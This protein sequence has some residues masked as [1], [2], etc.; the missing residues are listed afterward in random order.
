M[1]VVHP[2]PTNV[3]TQIESHSNTS[4][5]LS[6]QSLATVLHTL[7]GNALSACIRFGSLSATHVETIEGAV[8]SCGFSDTPTLGSNGD[9]S[10]YWCPGEHVDTAGHVVELVECDLVVVCIEK[11]ELSV[12]HGAGL[13]VFDTVWHTA[14]SDDL[15][16]GMAR[17]SVSS[18]NTVFDD[19]FNISALPDHVVVMFTHTVQATVCN[20]N[21]MN[22]TFDSTN[23]DNFFNT[24]ILENSAIF[25]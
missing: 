16:T 19:W 4:P 14:G 24:G 23:P 21:D 12:V 15:F 1:E 9:V 20:V 18:E 22:V 11:S 5:G 2:V 8:L 10:W 6:L 7:D 17:L 25:H 3:T 13:T